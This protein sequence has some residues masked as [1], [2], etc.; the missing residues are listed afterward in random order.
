MNPTAGHFGQSAEPLSLYYWIQSRIE[1]DCIDPLCTS[2]KEKKGSGFSLHRMG[3]GP[4]I[5]LITNV[6]T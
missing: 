1:D 3:H 5:A 4:F 2:V 6:I